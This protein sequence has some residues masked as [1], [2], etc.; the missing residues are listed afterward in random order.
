M[1]KEACAQCHTQGRVRQDC[2]LCHNY[3][4]EPAFTERVTRNEN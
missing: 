1:K 3:H 4:K 2:Q